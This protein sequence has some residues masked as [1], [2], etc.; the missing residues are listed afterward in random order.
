MLMYFKAK[1]ESEVRKKCSS[2][3][4]EAYA[5]YRTESPF[6]VINGS[7]TLR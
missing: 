5:A 6:I 4:L 7:S 1:D 3:I 2:Y